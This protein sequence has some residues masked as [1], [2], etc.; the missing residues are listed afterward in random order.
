MAQFR[1]T[2]PADPRRSARYGWD[3]AVGCFVE[4]IENR[5]VVVKYDVL[6]PGYDAVRPLEG[7]LLVLSAAGFFSCDD[8]G[9]AIIRGMQELPDEMP[10]HLA[11]VAEVI[12]NFRS[13]AD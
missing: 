13:A 9:E 6:N 2:H 11:G 10:A 8:I 1:L 3:H 4:V 12:A 7:A 5:R